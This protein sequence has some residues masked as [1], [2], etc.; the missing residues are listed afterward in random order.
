MKN[1]LQQLFPTLKTRTDV[2]DEIQS[3]PTLLSLFNEWTKEQQE[4]FLAFTTGARV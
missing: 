3:S 4:E 1:K 2:M